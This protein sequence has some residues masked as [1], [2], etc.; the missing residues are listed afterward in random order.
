MAIQM[1]TNPTVWK[2]RVLIPLWAIRIV[3]ML[4]IIAITGIALNTIKKDP[5]LTLPNVG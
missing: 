1:K 3:L 2:K 5:N 4:F